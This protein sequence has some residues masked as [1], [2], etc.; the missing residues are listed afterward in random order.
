MFHRAR[1]TPEPPHP[2]SLLPLLLKDKLMTRDDLERLRHPNRGSGMG[3]IVGH[4]TES[5]CTEG[6]PREGTI[7]GLRSGD[8]VAPSAWTGDPGQAS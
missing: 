2:S 1:R 7:R 3:T 5:L 4:E 6:Q 8:H